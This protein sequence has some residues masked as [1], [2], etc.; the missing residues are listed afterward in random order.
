[1]VNDNS[2]ADGVPMNPEQMREYLQGYYG[3]PIAIWKQGTTVVV[4]PFCSKK[5]EHGKEPGHHPAGCED[6]DRYIGIAIGDRQF[7]PSYGYT[8]CEYKESGGVNELIV[9]D[10]LSR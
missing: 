9:P 5:H 2:I 7:V 10:N 8:I 1:M 4:C 6:D 3:I